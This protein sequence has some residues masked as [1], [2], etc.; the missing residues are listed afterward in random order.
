MTIRWW[1]WGLLTAISLALLVFFVVYPLAVLFGNSMLD[2]TGSYSLAA[3]L[4]LARN[5][6]YVQAFRN[7]LML[8]FTV[9]TCTP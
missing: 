4:S 3:F 5:S 6:E 2:E 8:G 7:T 1:P 9:T